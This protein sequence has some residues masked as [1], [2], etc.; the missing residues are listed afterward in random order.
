M[1]GNENTGENE[2]QRSKV[3]LFRTNEK[4]TD[5]E[6][7]RGLEKLFYAAGFD[8]TFKNAGLAAIKT[9]FGEPGNKGW[10]PAQFIR[11]AAALVE[12][13]GAQA[14]VTDANTLYVGKRSNAYDHLKTAAAHGFTMDSL[15]VP[16]I[17]GDG[18]R[19]QNRATIPI[20]G[21]Y[22]RE[23]HLAPEIV[24]ADAL[25]AMTHVTG[26]LGSGYAGAIK[27][28][29][30]GCA[31]RGGKLAMHSDAKPQIIPDKCTACGTCAEYCP[32]DAITIADKAE[33][34]KTKCVG[35]GECYAVCRYRAV[36]FSWGGTHLQEKMVEY[37]MGMLK[38][39][40]GKVGY[41]N[42]ITYVTKN[43]NCM[44]KP[45]EPA[46]PDVGIVASADLVAVDA[47]SYDLVM[48]CAGKDFFAD[49][50]PALKSRTQLE[51]AEHLG[52][53]TVEY[54]LA[55]IS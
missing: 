2:M 27:N 43:C 30:M 19:G 31:S 36:Q 18:L 16:V 38:T 52:L 21:K 13:Q 37:A 28:I 49:T 42:F 3:Y 54:E 44:N 22:F 39:K 40:K 5:A 8:K 47:A 11:A 26:H 25:L 50:W 46:V 20:E 12:K 34:D 41:V 9:H 33:A 32:T 45:E 15:G 48:K 6:K 17:I 35:C 29:S 1:T 7:I 4:T 53:G 10:I 55:E 23:V 51:Y 14:F 24:H